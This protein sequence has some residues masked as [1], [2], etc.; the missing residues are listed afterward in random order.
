[1]E[2]F[3]SLSHVSKT[4]HGTR[5]LND[6]SLAFM[7]G[8]VHRLAGQ[9]GCG[10][11]TLIKIISGVYQ[12][13]AKARI[14]LGGKIWPKLT[15][16]ASVAQGIA[17]IYQDLS[18]L[19]HLSVWEN[20][21]IH[22]YHHGLLVKRKS[23]R[24]LGMLMTGQAFDYHIREPWQGDTA[25]KVLEVRQ[26]SR[27]GEYRDISFSLG[28]GEIVSIIGLLGRGVPDC[29]RRGRVFNDV[30]TQFCQSLL[31]GFLPADHHSG[32]G[33]GRCESRWRQRKDYRQGAGAGPAATH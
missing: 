3:L 1:M 25:R 6:I 19:P 22:H 5:A 23:L 30:E 21:V 33:A 16:G 8:E 26:L 14:A 27:A 11:S 17:V 4:F 12:P 13:D 18:L 31:K 29:Q 28:A 2:P 15:P 7:P 20:I 24:Q 10:K 9:N 32:G